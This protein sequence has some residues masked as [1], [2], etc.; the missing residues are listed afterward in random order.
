M[1]IL[2]VTVATALS[3]VVLPVATPAATPSRTRYSEHLT[4]SDGRYANR[5]LGHTLGLMFVNDSVRVRARCER[6]ATNQVRCLSTVRA[7]GFKARY[8]GYVVVTGA[9][10]QTVEVY[11]RG[12]RIIR[13]PSDPF[14]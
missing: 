8:I 6:I 1:R 9:R 7:E 11:M 14:P 10:N 13:Q 4:M 3:M 2:T 12:V 5:Y